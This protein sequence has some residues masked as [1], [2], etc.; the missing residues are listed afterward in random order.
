MARG[1]RYTEAQLAQMA[2][3]FDAGKAEVEDDSLVV[4][5]GSA[6]TGSVPVSEL[7]QLVA[8]HM[9]ADWTVETDPA[10][11]TAE[12]VSRST[13]PRGKVTDAQRGRTGK[14]TRRAK[15]AAG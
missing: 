10:A 4:D 14:T 7:L 3:D 8:S 12:K 15:S 6:A 11:R 9:G 13:L 1:T 2:A 5:D